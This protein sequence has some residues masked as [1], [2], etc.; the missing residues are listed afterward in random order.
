M[1]YVGFNALRVA[2]LITNHL[3]TAIL[4]TIQIWVIAM[5]SRI[6]AL[7]MILYLIIVLIINKNNVPITI[8]YINRHSNAWLALLDV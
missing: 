7:K 8:T 3:V 5:V 1:V 2:I 4:T 6:I